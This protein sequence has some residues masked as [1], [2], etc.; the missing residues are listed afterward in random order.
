[1]SFD[2]SFRQCYEES[3]SAIKWR[4][5]HS[6]KGGIAQMKPTIQPT[7]KRFISLD[8]ARGFM[9]SL[10]ALAHASLF[11]GSSLLSRPESLNI[12]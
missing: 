6:T 8:L 11:L 7:K 3:C 4:K 10:V 5:K 2:D 1:M 9:L 12:C